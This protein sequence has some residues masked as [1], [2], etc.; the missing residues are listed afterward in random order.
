VV[1]GR[2]EYDAAGL[3]E[4]FRRVYV[5]PEAR[6]GPVAAR[7]LY[8]PLRGFVAG[9]AHATAS[10]LDDPARLAA[11]TRAYDAA[12]GFDYERVERDYPGVDVF[13]VITV[14]V[15]W[16]RRLDGTLPVLVGALRTVLQDYDPQTFAELDRRLRVRPR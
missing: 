16:R 12:G 8:P 2:A 13:D 11:T 15:V 9:A 7:D 6:I 10:L 1:R 5:R 4:A 3:A 14:G